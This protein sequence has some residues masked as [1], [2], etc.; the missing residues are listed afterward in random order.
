MWVRLFERSSVMVTDRIVAV[1]LLTETDIELLGPGFNRLFPVDR[2]PHFTEL[3]AAIDR[4]D[5][6]FREEVD[7]SPILKID[8]A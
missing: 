2:T 8:S 6:Q 4:A 7:Q 3:L 5:Q 1:G